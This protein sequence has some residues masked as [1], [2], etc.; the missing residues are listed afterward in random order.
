MIHIL[1]LLILGSTFLVSLIGGFYTSWLWEQI[2][3]FCIEYL[4]GKPLPAFS[5]FAMRHPSAPQFLCL[6]PWCLFLGCTVWSIEEDRERWFIFGFLSWASFGGLMILILNSAWLLPG[7]SLVTFLCCGGEGW[8]AFELGSAAAVA[9]SLFAIVAL[10]V[11][12]WW[13]A[14]KRPAGS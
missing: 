10:T 6:L 2:E 8:T 11:P 14:R 9:I 3:P 1:R 7:L 4:P 12:R 13:R 5:D